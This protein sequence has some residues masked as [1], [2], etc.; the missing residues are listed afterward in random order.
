MALETAAGGLTISEQLLANTL[1]GATQFQVDTGSENSAEALTHIYFDSLPPSEDGDA[2]KPEE[3]IE[4]RPFAIVAIDPY[5]DGYSWGKIGSNAWD[6]AGRLLLIFNYN[7]PDELSN[8]NEALMRWFKNRIGNIMRPDPDVFGG[9]VGL[10][11]LAHTAG[12]HASTRMRFGQYG[13]GDQ[14]LLQT[15]GDFVLGT[16]IVEWSTGE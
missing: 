3:L 15:Q 9:Y 11:D 4:I 14:E 6:D 10:T 16:V 5:G 7:V 13:R 1:A 2:F 12:F 8:D